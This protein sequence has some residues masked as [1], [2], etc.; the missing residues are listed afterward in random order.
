M[1]CLSRPDT[2]KFF[3]G[4]YSQILLGPFLNTLS[5][6]FLL[7]IT[8]KWEL[9]FC[10]FVNRSIWVVLFLRKTSMD[11][12]GAF[13]SNIFMFRYHFPLFYRTLL[14]NPGNVPSP[15]SLAVP[16]SWRK[17]DPEIIRF[18]LCNT[19]LFYHRISF[20][21]ESLFKVMMS[22]KQRFCF[23]FVIWGNRKELE[24]RG[25]PDK[26]KSNK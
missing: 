18:P 13:N 20:L 12:G 16:H 3:K 4:C 6:F 26:L 23:S 19:G 24:W 2:L 14:S 15:P 5:H 1:A 25:L 9:S 7:S 21:R 17:L 8:V 10:R 22:S 11:N